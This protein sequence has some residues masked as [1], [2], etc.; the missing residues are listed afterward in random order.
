MTRCNNSKCDM[1]L[2]GRR[3]QF[4]LNLFLFLSSVCRHQNFYRDCPFS[5]A[6]FSRKGNSLIY[7]K[8]NYRKTT[9]PFSTIFGPQIKRASGHI[10]GVIQCKLRLLE[11][12]QNWYFVCL[13]LK[14]TNEIVI[15]SVKVYTHCVCEIS[16]RSES[17]S[18]FENQKSKY[19]IKIIAFLILG[20]HWWNKTEL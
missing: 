2:D 9:E 17:N 8:F 6:K 10:L 11:A 12:I 19:L 4:I 3:H 20:L 14:K 7:K 1:L 15:E 16:Q 18:I 13:L 5:V